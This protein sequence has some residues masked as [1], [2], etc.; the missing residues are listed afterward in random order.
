MIEDVKDLEDLHSE[1]LKLCSKYYPRVSVDVLSIVPDT[2]I[3]RSDINTGTGKV[4]TDTL[5]PSLIC[6][7]TA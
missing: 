4:Y 5:F 6:S 1:S 3:L 7:L 2:W